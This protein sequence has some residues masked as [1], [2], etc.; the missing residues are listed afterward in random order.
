MPQLKTK[1]LGVRLG[2]G[3]IGTI[4]A[5]AGFASATVVNY[6][7]FAGPNTTYSNV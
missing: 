4:L 1:T 3:V 5:S 7:N 2:A 6:G